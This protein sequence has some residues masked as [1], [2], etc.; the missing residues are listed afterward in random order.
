M[1]NSTD[2]SDTVIRHC[3]KA[4][5]TFPFRFQLNSVFMP[6]PLKLDDPGFQAVVSSYPT[7]V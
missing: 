2:A 3:M 6:N 5:K 4:I 1:A 7:G